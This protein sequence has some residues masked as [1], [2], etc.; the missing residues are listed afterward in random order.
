MVNMISHKVK[1]RSKHLRYKLSNRCLLLRGNGY[2]WSQSVVL[3]GFHSNIK[4]EIRFTVDWMYFHPCQHHDFP[5]MFIMWVV[6]KVWK[7]LKT[8]R[9]RGKNLGQGKP[10]K[11]GEFYWKKQKRVSYFLMAELKNCSMR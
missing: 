1:H 2:W 6:S 3:G 11:V 5:N 7:T 8:C 9:S 10:G 4:H